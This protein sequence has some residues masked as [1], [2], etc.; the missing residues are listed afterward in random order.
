M[1]ARLQPRL[2][3]VDPGSRACGVAA[4]EDGFLVKASLVRTTADVSHESRAAEAAEMARA[5]FAWSVAAVGR[6]F[7]VAVEWP[8]V[9]ATKIRQGLTKE[10]PN[11]LLILAGVTSAFASACGSGTKVAS[12]APSDWKGQMPKEVCRGRISARLTAAEEFFLATAASEVHE[13]LSH[14][15]W[16]AVG[17]GLHHLRRLKPRRGSRGD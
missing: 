13:R 3:S 2:V 16:D 15:I 12:Y 9:Y 11:D 17:V 6:D 14:N 5:L 1:T 4:F 8:R 10:D 7:E